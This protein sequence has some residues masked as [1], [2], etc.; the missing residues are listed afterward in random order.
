METKRKPS[1]MYTIKQFKKLIIKLEQLKLI[2]TEDA[3]KLKEI[4]KSTI[5]KWVGHKI[6]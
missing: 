1:E 2:E 6:Y 3:E 4:H 5:N